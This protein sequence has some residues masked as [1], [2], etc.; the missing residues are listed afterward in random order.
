VRPLRIEIKGFTCF[1]KELAVSFEEMD[2]FAITGRTGSG[3]TT[4][5]DAMCYALYGRVPRGTDVSGLVAHDAEKMYVSL[6]FEAGGHVYRAF[7]G[8]TLNK[9]TLTGR[10]AVQLE[11]RLADG[12]WEPIENR[13]REMKTAVEEIVGLDFDAFTRCVLLPQGRFQE[14]LVGKKEDRR[15]VLE[16]LLDIGV[17]ERIMQR[18]NR[19]RRD[20]DAQAKA[21]EQVLS[22]TFAGATPEALE[23][24]RK[25]LA[26]R[27]PA[28]KTARQQRDAL[29]QAAQR[30]SDVRTA[31]KSENGRREQLAQKEKDLA[32]AESLAQGGQARL[33]ALRAQASDAE[34]ALKAS[35][36][37]R[38]LHTSLSAARGTAQ[39]VE[40][41]A[42][43]HAAA[44]PAASDLGG[45]GAASATL[46][47]AEADATQAKS[48]LSSAEQAMEDARRAH[49]AAHLRA[50]LKAGDTCPVC[51]NAVG[52]LPRAREPALASIE[53]ALATAKTAAEQT[54]AK[55]NAAANAHALAKQK[56]EQA[57][58][59]AES[60]ARELDAA[61]KELMAQLPKGMAPDLAAIA[62]RLGELSDLGK[63]FDA[64][65]A[66]AEQLRTQRDAYEGRMAQSAEAIAGLRGEVKALSDAA[67][68]DRAKGDEA[69]ALLSEIVKRWMWGGVADLI[70]SK[71]D[72]STMLSRM[73]DAAQKECDGLER[74]IGALEGE[75]KR[76]ERDIKQAEAQRAQ[77]AGLRSQ[78][79]LYAT[80]A[81]LLQANRFRDWYIGEAMT[82]LADA[83]SDRLQTLDP[84]QRYA[85][86][87][88]EGEFI[89]LDRWQAN[90]T[91][92]PETLSGGETFV[93]SLALA[94]ALAEQLPQIQ[95]SSAATLESLFLDE[96]FGT[97][98]ADTL[99]PVMSALEGLRL[100]GRLVG[101]VTHVRELA[102]RIGTRIE[103]TKSPEG[104]SVTVVG[105]ATAGERGS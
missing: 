102:E 3:K 47:A 36:Y 6:D 4:I 42:R 59:R 44:H 37:D 96:G 86:Q 7:R 97:L 26:D 11:R 49:S 105:G 20:L 73:L 19:E 75:T 85:L 55:L 98:D 79:G 38:A 95:A 30:A 31:R 34:A 70:A 14:M 104:S 56:A 27:K 83:A 16:D 51:A 21:I 48:A 17:Y 22:S 9:K 32:D 69:I 61:R 82:L 90:A 29:Q 39:Q 99:D 24:S 10:P 63:R 67:D 80:L 68:D 23:A 89:V 78:I 72:P 103:V 2:V 58:A 84:D 35:P 93:V 41:L 62:A 64:L 1:S 57:A 60:A 12:E 65:S 52:E 5:M 81:D 15:K 33:D 87:V 50:G 18:A 53:K 92:P 28:L 77:L 74:R 71:T 88:H 45:V 40:R 13:A 46:A 25:E 76:I 54:S 91:R 101:I 66:Q 43:E 8:I 94:L 100:E